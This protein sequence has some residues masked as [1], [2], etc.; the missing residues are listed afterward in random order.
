METVVEQG[1][2]EA[3]TR[4]LQLVIA[5]LPSAAPTDHEEGHDNDSSSNTRHHL[6]PTRPPLRGNNSDDDEASG[7][8]DR[9]RDAGESPLVPVFRRFSAPHVYVRLANFGVSLLEK[10]ALGCDPA[11]VFPLFFPLRMM[12]RARDYASAISLLRTLLS[13]PV[14][15]HKRGH[16]FDRLTVNLVHL[17]RKDEAIREC[18]RG[19][20]DPF[21]RRGGLITLQVRPCHFRTFP[22]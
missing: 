7:D 1:D 9:A 22:R 16:W 10:Y 11:I 8:R 5:R 3:A 17:H 21:V 15:P 13:Q 19:L 2:D 14:L 6:Q 12:T 18:E 20:A 4:C